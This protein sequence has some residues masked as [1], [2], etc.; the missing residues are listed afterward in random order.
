[1]IKVTYDSQ[2]FVNQK[3]GGISR[4]F[5]EISKIINASD[6][7]STE[8]IAPLYFNEYLHQDSSLVKGLHLNLPKNRWTNKLS[9]VV[10]NITSPIILNGSKSHILHETYYQSSSI[11][12]KNMPIV[13]TVYDMIHERFSKYFSHQ[14]T[15][16]EYKRLAVTRADHIICISHNTRSD[17]I[18]LFNI[19]P[20][21][22][23]VTHLGFSLTENYQV[24]TENPL[25][26]PYIFYVGDRVKYKNFKSLLNA[27]ANS[28]FLKNNFVLVAFGGG[29][30]SEGEKRLMQELGLEEDK[31]IQMSGKDD[32]LASLYQNATV[33]VYPSLYEGFGIPPL[34]AMS[35]NCP[36]VCSNVSSIP[37]VVGDA[38]QYFN[39]LDV[40]DIQHSI[41]TV[42][43]STELKNKLIEKG[44]KQLAKFSW[45]T[46][47]KQTMDI[48]RQILT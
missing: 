30:F 6:D 27:F 11:V 21:K 22:T 8:I 32:V 23:S 35:Y 20:E 2:A 14:D 3:W 42:I 25:G 43:Q 47:A 34:E 16:S 46:C 45:D 40:E 28:E 13:I 17:L 26:K 15:T 39:P 31:V 4:Y 1:M 41:E 7:F 44:K 12:S 29:N 33:F 24:K 18:E 38:G 5:Y 37:E 9:R 19:P 48:Y 36:V 10:N